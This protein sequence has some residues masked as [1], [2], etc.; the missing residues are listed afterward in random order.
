[1][2]LSNGITQATP[3]C[4]FDQRMDPQ[5]M[6]KH[7]IEIDT[8]KRVKEVKVK[9]RLIGGLFYVK[10]IEF[11]DSDGESLLLFETSTEKGGD[12]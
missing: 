2:E 9:T 7:E 4:I 6:N 11:K 12:W 10:G 5:N 1:M 3:I 8:T